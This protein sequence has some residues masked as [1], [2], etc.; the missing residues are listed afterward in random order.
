MNPEDA[1]E[2][3]E[4]ADSN[5]YRVSFNLEYSKLRKI[6]VFREMT[7]LEWKLEIF[8][9]CPLYFIFEVKYNRRHK[10]CYIARRNKVKM[11][12]I[13]VSAT[14][15][16]NSTMWLIIIDVENT[17]LNTETSEKIWTRL[18]ESFELLSR[19]K[20]CIINSICG[21][22]SSGWYFQL[23]LRAILYE[24]GFALSFCNENL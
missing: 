24:M 11:D 23:N 16:K 10:A 20:V 12:N 19:M 1:E 21:L 22:V 14:T 7:E 15:T 8:K 6:L 18:G 9:F 4:L 17:Y 2:V 3:N 13:D 5:K